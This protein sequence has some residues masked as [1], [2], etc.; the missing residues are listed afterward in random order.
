MSEFLLTVQ[1]RIAKEVNVSI[2]TNFEL[3]GEI[4]WEKLDQVA[5]QMLPMHEHCGEYF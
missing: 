3:K 5:M 4:F 2:V 1:E